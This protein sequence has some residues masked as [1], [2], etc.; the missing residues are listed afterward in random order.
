MATQVISL[1]HTRPG[2]GRVVFETR[3]A[4]ALREITNVLDRGL[5]N[6][7][8][9]VVDTAREEGSYENRTGN[10]RR[11]ITPNHEHALDDPKS[12]PSTPVQVEESDGRVHK[13]QQYHPPSGFDDIKI[14]KDGDESATTVAAVMHYAG[15]LEARGHDVLTGSVDKVITNAPK[16][17]GKAFESTDL[18]DRRTKAE[19]ESA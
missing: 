15:P 7:T 11:L 1:P 4:E 8:Q 10:L 19:R 12:Y 16:I 3:V 5:V 2:P 13:R 9:Q 17:M 14:E 18:T 6:I